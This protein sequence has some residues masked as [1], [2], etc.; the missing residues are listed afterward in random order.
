MTDQPTNP[1]PEP[2][3]ITVPVRVGPQAVAALNARLA[4]YGALGRL[5]DGD[6]GCGRHRP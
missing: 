2:P 6:P 1:T 5:L 3:P 4:A